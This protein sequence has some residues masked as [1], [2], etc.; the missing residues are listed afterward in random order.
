M[1]RLIF[2]CILTGISAAGVPAQTADFLLASKPDELILYNKYQQK[3]TAHQLRQIPA[4]TPWKI[5]DEDTLLSDRFTPV[6]KVERDKE[7]YFIQL[8]DEEETDTGTVSPVPGT[9]IYRGCTLMNDTIQIK[10]MN[11]VA[12]FD[13]PAAGAGHKRFDLDENDLLLIRA[14]HKNSYLVQTME[15]LPRYGWLRHSQSRYW[16]TVKTVKGGQKPEL[17]GLIREQIRMRIRSANDQYR[18]YFTFMNQRYQKQ[19]VIPE[20]YIE[21]TETGLRCTMNAGRYTESLAQ[22]TRYLIQD[23]E[24]YLI[25]TPFRLDYEAGIIS[26]YTGSKNGSGT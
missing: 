23:L 1:K 17:P 14:R 10:E 13:S 5:I 11:R 21:E 3:V 20:W 2:A 6:M 15:R 24:G 22:S 12:L 7:T 25:G 26:I 19:L 18:Q 9:R 8:P 4:Y 16:R